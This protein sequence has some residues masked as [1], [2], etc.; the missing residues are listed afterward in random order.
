MSQDEATRKGA[1]QSL[2]EQVIRLATARSGKI[3]LTKDYRDLPQH[4]DAVNADD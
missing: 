3:E 4:P 1:F 2:E